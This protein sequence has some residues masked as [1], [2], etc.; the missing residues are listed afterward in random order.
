MSGFPSIMSLPQVRSLG[1]QLSGFLFVAPAFL[2]LLLIILVPFLLSIYLSLTNSTAGSW[3]MFIGLENYRN[4]LGS[5]I[6]RRTFRNSLIFTGASIGLKTAIGTALALLFN[7]K[8]KGRKFFRG[9]ILLPW[10]AP[11]SL[12]TLA[13]LWIFNPVFGVANQSLKGLGLIQADIP[14]LSQPALALLCVIL[15][16][17]WRGAPFF[18][19]TIL[20]GLSSVP[21]QL[22]EAAK[23][24]GAGTWKR[25]C[26][27]TL[28]LIQPILIIVILFSTIMTFSDFQIVYILTNGGPANSTHL[29]ATLAYQVGMTGGNTGGGATIL[30]FML[31]FL[32]L[33]IY[34][35]LRIRGGDF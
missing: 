10:I 20:A 17:T 28:P 27:V 14:W 11:A 15:V 35:Q 8:L 21:Q 30:L 9:A 7:Q 13:W 29:F 16:N 2:W 12:S 18:V 6:F 34:L 26:H 3:G 4:L 25:F 22:Y 19:I 24:D 31:P 33:L 23:V 5:E 1:R 32:A